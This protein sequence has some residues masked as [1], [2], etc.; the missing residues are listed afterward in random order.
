VKLMEKLS[1]DEVRRLAK[2]NDSPPAVMAAARK[3][4]AGGK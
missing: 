2:S 3:K 4:V 1:M